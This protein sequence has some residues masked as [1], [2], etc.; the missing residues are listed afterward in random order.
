MLAL[1]IAFVAKGL[2][3]RC[4][5]SRHGGVVPDLDGLVHLGERLFGTRQGQEEQDHVGA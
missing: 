5:G 4:P 1:P 2:V 3:Q